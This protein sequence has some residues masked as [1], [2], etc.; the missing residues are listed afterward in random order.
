MLMVPTFSK[1]IT[2]LQWKQVYKKNNQV[3]LL[4]LALPKFAGIRWK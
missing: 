4:F 3:N 2:I 1:M